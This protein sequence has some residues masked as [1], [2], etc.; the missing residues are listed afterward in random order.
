M[1]NTKTIITRIKNKIDTISNWND[2]K[3]TLLDGEVAIVKVPTG[4]S[5]TNPVTGEPEPVIELLMKVGDGSSTFDKLP[6]MSA[7]ASDVYAWAKKQNLDLGDMPVEALL[8]ELKKT[9]Y[10]ESEIDS[11]ITALNQAISG[12]SDSGHNHDDSY[13]TEAEVDEKIAVAVSSAL[14]YK[15]TKNK[16]SDLPTSNN[17]IG[18]VWNIANACAASES[19]PKVNAGD[20]VAWNG[21]SWDVL[22]GTVDLSGYYTSSQVDSALQGKSNAGHGHNYAGSNSDGGAAT[23]AN[24]VNKAVTFNNSSGAAAGTTF[25]GSAAVTVSY[26]TVGAAAASHNHTK[27]E[28]TDFAHDHNDAYYT[29]VQV[30]SSLSGKA[31]SS[32][33][34]HVPATETADNAK[35]LRNDNTWQTVTPANIGAAATSHIHTKSEITDFAHT[36]DDRYYTE[37]EIDSMLSGKAPSGSYVSYSQIGTSDN[38]NMLIGSDTVIFD[39]GGASD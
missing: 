14:K 35:F 16:T 15:G 18:D 23:S 34:N 37:S 33:G 20:N 21:S 13:Y 4:S 28:I 38:Y 8:T 29:K 17:A 11:K 25:D 6:W 10:T 3:G 26:V 22:A 5:Y 39:C 12:K 24:K 19:L 31:N 36:H 32:H 1:A 27:S 2:Y 7:K 9:F 30:D